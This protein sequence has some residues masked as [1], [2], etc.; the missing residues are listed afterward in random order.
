MRRKRS[1]RRGTAERIALAAIITALMLAGGYIQRGWV[2]WTGALALWTLG[3]P[4]L[5]TWRR[6]EAEAKEKR[7]R[8]RNS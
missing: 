2:D 5:L 1:H 7:A 8:A 4:L 3:L 6:A